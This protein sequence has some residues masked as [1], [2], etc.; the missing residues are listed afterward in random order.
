M[1]EF[2]EQLTAVSRTAAQVAASCQGKNAS[3]VLSSFGDAGLLGAIA[4]EAA[5]GLELPLAFAAAIVAAS[6]PELL[7][8]AIAEAL[9][10]AR[11]VAQFDPQIAADIAG[12]RVLVA[13]SLHDGLAATRAGA[14][15]S[16]SG[17]LASVALADQARWL[18]AP[19]A[20]GG[21]TA[22]MLLDL[23]APGVRRE[24]A[25][26][27]E[28]ERSRAHLRFTAVQAPAQ[29][30]CADAAAVDEFR[31]LVHVLY[32][33]WLAAQAR[34]CLMRTAEHLSTRRQF[35]SALASLQTVRFTL[36]RCALELENLRWLLEG[37]AEQDAQAAA[38]QATMAYAYAAAVCPGI[39]EKCLHLHGGMGYTWDVPVHRLLRRLR[40]MTDDY[41]A[42]AAREQL[43]CQTI[44][45][46]ASSGGGLSGIG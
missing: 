43:A 14:G 8:D 31:A 42:G 37:A 40:A 46:C 9:I 12:G 38:L 23:E 13:L 2:D 45:V 11:V 27:L 33:H 22:L 20:Q 5:G 16:V 15:F 28:L 44:D 21:G 17:S 26:T 35:G 7:C 6:A 25:D 30:L 3:E 39:V 19:V 18:V 10:G 24:Q 32:S 4:S 41:T 29:H 1:N 36:A 34:A